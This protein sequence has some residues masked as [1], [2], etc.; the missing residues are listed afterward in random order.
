MKKKYSKKMPSF[1][2]P[3]WAALAFFGM[4]IA[5]FSNA[6]SLLAVIFSIIGLAVF[7]RIILPPQKDKIAKISGEIAFSLGRETYFEGLP[8]LSTHPYRAAPSLH[9]EWVTGWLNAQEE[10]SRA[11]PDDVSDLVEPK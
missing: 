10:I 4:S 7:A 11:M 2:I 8:L 3:R 1:E 5:N 6:N 9:S